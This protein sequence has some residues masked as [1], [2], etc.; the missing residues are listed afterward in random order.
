MD[1]NSAL[2]TFLAETT[3]HAPPFDAAE[4]SE[5]SRLYLRG[6]DSWADRPELPAL[7]S[8]TVVRGRFNELPDWV[9]GLQRLGLDDCVVGS[10]APLA[11]SQTLGSVSLQSC[12]VTDVS[13]LVR[14]SRLRLVRIGGC[15]VPVDQIDRLREHCRVALDEDP[16]SLELVRRLHARGLAASAY[17]GKG[18]IWVRPHLGSG[19][20]H[21]SVFDVAPE[22]F[23]R[24][25]A[26][27]SLG[28]R[29]L[30][31]LPSKPA[32][33]RRP[34][35]RVTRIEMTA[36]E[37][38]ASVEASGLPKQEKWLAARVVKRFP[39][40]TFFRFAEEDLPKLEK[41]EGVSF[42]DHLK[43]W[44]VTLVGP[45]HSARFGR[46]DGLTQPTAGLWWNIHLRGG[47]T[48]EEQ[49]LLVN[50][51]RCFPIAEDDATGLVLA[52][53]LE[54][55]HPHLVYFSSEYAH[56]ED[57]FTDITSERRAF[58]SYGRMLDTIEALRI[59]DRVVEGF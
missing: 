27:P 35:P 46:F 52:T 22:E 18:V 59:G 56:D 15:P 2:R 4:L 49:H 29:D 6:V 43:A 39:E 55:E 42:P 30:Q 11:G 12:P 14:C 32:A 3:G 10:L 9:A 21:G 5:I 47:V 44:I 23:E 16:E 36:E 20:Q 25:M 1:F 34:R 54:Q 37:A 58:A 53:G 7:K 13:P 28:L 31:W 38:L 41:R 51:G 45:A 19:F 48:D 26:D 33:P 40:A 17:W 8:L 24:V 57:G 50:R